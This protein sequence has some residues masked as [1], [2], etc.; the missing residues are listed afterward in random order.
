MTEKHMIYRPEWTCG[1]YDEEHQVAIYY[2]LIEGMAYFFE[3]D[4][5]CV[6]GE[7]LNI[8]RNGLVDIQ[9]IS[10]KAGIDIE[11]LVS[12]FK[13]LMNYGLLVSNIPEDETIREYRN[14]VLLSKQKHVKQAATDFQ[15]Q[16]VINTTNAERLYMD[17]VDG[18]SSVM[19]ELT[20]RCSEMC[21]HC[22]NPGA[23]RN[24]KEIN[25]RGNRIE[26]DL[27]DYKRIIDELYEQGLVKV[28]LSGGDPFSKS[29]V[30]DIIDYL[31]KKGIAIDIF[32]NGISVYKDVD[33]LARYYPRTIGISLYSNN[34]FVHDYITRVKGSYEKTIKFIQ[35]CSK[36]GLSMYLKC[37]IM[38]PNVKSYYTVKEVAYKYGALPQFDLNIT[39]SA[40]GDTCASTNLR[41]THE[42]MEIVLRD[43]NLPYYIGKG[44][45]KT[46]AQ[47]PVDP[48]GK[49]CNAGF[50]SICITPEGN[51][52]PCCAFPM[53][54]GN[55]K[56]SSIK[57]E[58]SNNKVYNWWKKRTILDCT[59]CRKHP[60]C[61]F[62]QMCVGNN[63]I[64]HGTP[65]KPSE[66][67]CFIAKERYNLAL[68]MKDG[69]DP[70]QGKKLEE[71]LND[72]EVVVT[73]L[74]RCDSVNYRNTYG[75]N[76][77]SQ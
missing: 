15:D 48:N 37:C 24:D 71:R 1:R 17:R 76:E 38:K 14:N 33:R 42:M 28:C 22:Y 70:L 54:L 60:Y 66:N 46:D 63:F 2:N 5:A 55:I 56:Q 16:S 19:F 13:L 6:I 44:L 26:L 47:S 57:K 74:F 35:E 45:D 67:N 61:I 32:T 4:S 62:C 43:E 53:M 10:D 51:L 7:I 30:W 9:F 39:D 27:N 11:D 68:K 36:Y 72:L 23:T 34:S 8:D 21:I 69:Y 18:L 73:P 58:L 25:E 64:A 3:D 12:F 77:M 40:E 31:Y 49:M 50:T 52:Q 75:I 20:Y 59:D 41:L 65:L 29:I